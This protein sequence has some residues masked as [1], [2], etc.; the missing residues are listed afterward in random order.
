MVC[1][2]PSRK[3]FHFC[4]LLNHKQGNQSCG[5]KPKQKRFTLVD[6]YAKTKGGTVGQN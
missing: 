1:Y 4:V 3:Q 2:T 6:A 5:K